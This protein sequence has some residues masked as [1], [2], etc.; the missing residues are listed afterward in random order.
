MEN[1]PEDIKNYEN[2][3]EQDSSMTTVRESQEEGQED[4]R[5]HNRKTV[6]KVQL[7]CELYWRDSPCRWPTSPPSLALLLSVPDKIG[8]RDLGW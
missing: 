1:N 6:K 3:Q 5:Q 4:S 7:T 2:T 8:D